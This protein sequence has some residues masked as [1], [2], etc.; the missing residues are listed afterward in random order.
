[1][2]W[3][4]LLICAS[5]YAFYNGSTSYL[6]LI[7]ISEKQRGED[8]GILGKTNNAIIFFRAKAIFFE[9]KTNAITTECYTCFSPISP[10]LNEALQMLKSPNDTLSSS[11]TCSG[12][13]SAEW[14]Y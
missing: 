1:V 6:D 11:P 3:L 8:S 7:K 4:L 10:L 13:S 9:K 12:R 5:F 14:S 2:D